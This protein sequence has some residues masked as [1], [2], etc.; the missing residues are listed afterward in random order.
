M[1][2]SEKGCY[3]GH[4][5]GLLLDEQGAYLILVGTPGRRK[6]GGYRTIGTRRLFDRLPVRRRR[7][8]AENDQTLKGDR[9]EEGR[10]MVSVRE[11]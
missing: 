9:S 5:T 10:H 6:E 4:S 2:A 3:T 1:E 11:M 7:T 8:D